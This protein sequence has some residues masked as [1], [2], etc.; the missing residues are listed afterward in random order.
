MKFFRQPPAYP[1]GQV[2]IL[3]AYALT[4][5]GSETTWSLDSASQPSMNLPL[6]GSL[7]T[8]G[9]DL[10]SSW[11]GPPTSKMA[12]APPPMRISLL[13]ITIAQALG[14]ET[15]PAELAIV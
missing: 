15:L 7:H 11:P 10:S 5:P 13:L 12:L 3:M 14:W 1:A 6:V 8:E 2:S 4:C 9:L